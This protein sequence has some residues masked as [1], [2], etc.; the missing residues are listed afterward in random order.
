MNVITKPEDQKALTAGMPGMRVSE[1]ILKTSQFQVMRDWY[2]VLFGIPPFFLTDDSGG[3]ESTKGI[4]FFRLHMDFPFSQVV[5]IFEIEGSGG[6]PQPGPGMHHMQ[7][8]QPDFEVLVTRYERLGECGIEPVQSWNH[9]PSTSFYYN[10]PDGNMVE[11]SASNYPTEEGYL[12][13]FSTEAYRKAFEGIPIDVDD[14]VAKY[15]G[16]MALA[17]L[18]KIEA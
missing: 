7:L 13:Y 18:S 4:A 6:P 5:G 14:Y 12:A 15:R 3:W 11:L 9:G 16:G 2:E 1:V 10:D 8:R 17:E